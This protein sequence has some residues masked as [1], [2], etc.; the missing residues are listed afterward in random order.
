M[1]NE[2]ADPAV[3]GYRRINWTVEI[4][5]GD[6]IEFASILAEFENQQ[7]L[8][9]CQSIIIEFNKEDPQHQRFSLSLANSVKK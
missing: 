6:V 7:P 9:E 3:E 1:L 5:K 8:V 4:P 2:V